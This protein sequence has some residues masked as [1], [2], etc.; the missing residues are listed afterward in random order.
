MRG[1][2]SVSHRLTAGVQRRAALRM[3]R[4]VEVGGLLIEAVHI[5]YKDGRPSLDMYTSAEE[6]RRAH[7]LQEVVLTGNSNGGQ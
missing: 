2:Q 6:A 1:L 3:A 5:G 4:S 7:P